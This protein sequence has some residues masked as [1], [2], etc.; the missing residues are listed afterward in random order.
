MFEISLTQV[1]F[2]YRL[3]SLIFF[4]EKK[5]FR[6]RCLNFSIIK[7]TFRLFLHFCIYIFT[8]TFFD[9]YFPL[10]FIFIY[11]LQHSDLI[12]NINSKINSIDLVL[13]SCLHAQWS[14]NLYFFKVFF[15]QFQSK[16]FQH[17]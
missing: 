15:L 14:P 8:F 6:N 2:P 16:F 4:S 10:E 13:F 5:T 1:V 12:P 3:S 7:V 11:V 17:C 9:D